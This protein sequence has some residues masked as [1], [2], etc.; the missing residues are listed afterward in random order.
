[1][2]LIDADALIKMIKANMDIFCG[3]LLCRGNVISFLFDLIK[4]APTIDT[5]EVVHGQWE[6]DKEDIAWGNPLKKKRCTNCGKRPHFDKVKWEFILSDFCPN[7][8]AKMDK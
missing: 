7:C 1:M 6:T 4:K 8:G 5:V 3:L 2:R